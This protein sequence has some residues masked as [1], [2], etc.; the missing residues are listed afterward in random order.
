LKHSGFQLD[1]SLRLCQ[2]YDWPEWVQQMAKFE[3]GLLSC[4]ICDSDLELVGKQGAILRTRCPS[5]GMTSN[6]LNETYLAAES[7]VE[8]YYHRGKAPASIPPPG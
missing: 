2:F 4:S 1:R 8:V 6:D 3:T 7:K 5:C